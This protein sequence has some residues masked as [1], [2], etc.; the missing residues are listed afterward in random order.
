MQDNGNK[1]NTI[2]NTSELTPVMVHY[3]RNTPN[4]KI[5]TFLSVNKYNPGAL[6]FKLTAWLSI[7][8]LGKLNFII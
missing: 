4:L 6:L 8:W 1:I 7:L 5:Q 3:N 2:I